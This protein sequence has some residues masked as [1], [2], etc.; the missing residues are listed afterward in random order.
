MDIRKT[1][2]ALASAKGPS[3]FEQPVAKS[4]QALIAPYVDETYFDR[5][6]SL[7]GVRRCGKENAPKLLLD[8][9]LDEI[10]LMVTGIEEGFLRFAEIGGVD[11]RMLPDR[12]VTVLCDPPLTGVIACLPPHV[13][14]AKDHD[15][16]MSMEELYIDVG[17]SQEEAERRIP[18]GTPITY[19][20]GCFALGES[21]IC[22]KSMDDRACFT[23]LLRCAELLKDEELDVDLYL[24]GSSREEVNGAGAMCG[25]FALAPDVCVAVDVTH[26]DSPDAPKEKTFSLGGGPV[27]G[28]GPNCVKRLSTALREAAKA[29]D[30]PIQLEVM[31]GHTGT[32]A[33]G[34]QV[35]REGIATA[36]LSIPLRYMHT[37]VEV[38]DLDDLEKTAQLLAAFVKDYGKEGAA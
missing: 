5:L 15:K 27:V 31:T 3:G 11:P 29:R 26:G 23:A 30:I 17:L 28:L 12:E 24:M 2:E 37:P 21:R 38:L 36:V 14:T 20:C 7:I 13:Q 1:L 8:A 25:A 16:A 34:V 32:N 9:H 4:A 22:G 6:G 18:I 35:A 19:R 33:W 10:G